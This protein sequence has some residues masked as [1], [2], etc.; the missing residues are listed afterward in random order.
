MSDGLTELSLTEV[1]S[2]IR[3]KKVSAVEVTR[4]CLERHRTLAADD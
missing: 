3:R 2:L 1:A 4:A